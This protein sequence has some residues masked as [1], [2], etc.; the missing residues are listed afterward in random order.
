MLP[1]TTFADSCYKD[2]FLY[3]L[4]IVKDIY[5][6]NLTEEEYNAEKARANSGDFGRESAVTFHFKAA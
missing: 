2:M 6:P 1:A 4:Y 5:I 3:S